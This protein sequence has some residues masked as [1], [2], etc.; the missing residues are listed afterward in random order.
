M[1]EARINSQYRDLYPRGVPNSGLF[2]F[3][4]EQAVDWAVKQAQTQPQ[5]YFGYIHLLP[6]HYPY[7]TRREF[8]DVFDDGWEPL[9]KPAHFFSD[10]YPQS[11]LT[12]QRRFYDEYIAYVDAEFGRLYDTLAQQGLLEN[13]CLV[14]TSD[15]G[16]MFERGILEHNTAT[17]F[18]PL[19]RVPLLIWEPGIKQRQDVRMPTSGVDLLPTLLH[20]AGQPVPDWFEGQVLPPFS[21]M[22]EDAERSV[23]AVEAKLNS[24]KGP[25]TKATL[26]IVKGRYKL[27]YYKGYPGYDEVYELYDLEDDP[28]ELINLYS[29]LEVVAGPLRSELMQK[30]NR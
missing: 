1:G 8:L 17:L 24:R 12:L 23:F 10:G 7:V 9:A 26:C 20:L 29:D 13:T 22:P 15:H 27:V 4:I 3:T 18:E 5:P 16:E 21:G 6:P 28:E 14:F 30:L 25:L 19:L 11:F 2:F